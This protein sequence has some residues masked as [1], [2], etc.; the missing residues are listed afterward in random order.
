MRSGAWLAVAAALLTAL[1]GCGGDDDE[2]KGRQ[3]PAK[4]QGLKI[5]V[6]THGKASDPFWSVVKKGAET[7]GDDLG[8]K[9]EYRAPERFDMARMRRLIDAAVASKP[10]GL[11]VSIPDPDVLGPAIRRA[12]AAG[13]PVV[14][15]NAGADVSRRLGALTHVGQSELAAGVAAGRRMRR[16]G[17]G[18]ALCINQEVG[19]AALDLR[20]QGF[21]RGL[22]REVRV[23]AVE[24]S[25]PE[26]AEATVASALR[27]DQGIDGVLT[28]GP[29]GAEPAMA[30]VERE[31]G[32]GVTMATF[33]LGEPVLAAIRD[34][35]ILFAVDQ[36]QFL[37]GYLPVEQLT[38]Y[39]QYGVIPSSAT[40]TGPAFV[41]RENAERVS[42]LSRRGLR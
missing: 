20:C 7:A 17:V 2:A 41:T 39:R 22:A 11:A 15:L 6:V 29:S 4:R 40:L 3:N 13:I 12:V 19:N 35:R 34:G 38:L 31:G 1:A 32:G 14:S 33:G 36:Q 5:A 21:E 27:R 23:L 25:D 10:A 9:V 24:L 8:V 16:Q 28:L 42:E 37:Q 26:G 18:R 30:A